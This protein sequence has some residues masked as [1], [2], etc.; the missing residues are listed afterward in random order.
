[1]ERP[2][3]EQQHH[4]DHRDRGDH[5][6]HDGLVAA[7]E[8]VGGDRGRP[9]DVCLHAFGGGHTVDEFPDGGDGTVGRRLPLIADKIQLNVGGFAVG[10]LRAR[11]GQRITPE[12]LDVLN[13]LRVGLQPADDVLVVVM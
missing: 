12:V 4:E 2:V 13:V 11:G 3:D 10:A 5:D 6:L 9:G 8:T 1:D 7:R